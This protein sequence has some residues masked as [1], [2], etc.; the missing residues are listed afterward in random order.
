MVVWYDPSPGDRDYIRAQKY[1]FLGQKIGDEFI[2]SDLANVVSRDPDVTALA[3]G[4]FAVTYETA[5]A[6]I[7]LSIFNASGTRGRRRDLA[8]LT[9]EWRR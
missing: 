4:G 7:D 6:S 5:T 1:G 8:I 2:V 9:A 3:N